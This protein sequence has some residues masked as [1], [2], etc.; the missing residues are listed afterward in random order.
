MAGSSLTPILSREEYRSIYLQELAHEARNQAFNLQA[1]LDWAMTGDSEQEAALASTL[2]AMPQVQVDAEVQQYLR[3]LVVPRDFQW[4]YSRLNLD[5]KK[6]IIL[7]YAKVAE[8]LTKQGQRPAS[9]AF[10]LS[11]IASMY[12]NNQ[13][14]NTNSASSV[15]N[16]NAAMLNSAQAN[17]ASNASTQT[18]LPAAPSNYLNREV[19]PPPPRQST[20]NATAA[21]SR[22]PAFSQNE[23]QQSSQQ[24]TPASQRS[25]ISDHVRNLTSNPSIEDT[26][27]PSSGNNNVSTAPVGFTGEADKPPPPPG[28][29]PPPPLQ[30]KRQTTRPAR[31]QQQPP[32]PPP[33]QQKPPPPPGRKKLSAPPVEAPSFAEQ[34][35]SRS[36]ELKPAPQ[37]PKRVKKSTPL[38]PNSSP[39][40]EAI[41]SVK[42]KTTQ[43]AS[44]EVK[45][46][47]LE[48]QIESRRQFI[49]Q[50]EVDSDE[51]D[52]EF[53]DREDVRDVI[54][55]FHKDVGNA[56]HTNSTAVNNLNARLAK[57]DYM[58]LNTKSFA[59]FNKVLKN[60]AQ[61]IL[62]RVGKVG[63]GR[64]SY[65]AGLTASGRGLTAS[66][67]G[68]KTK[69]K[70]RRYLQGAGA[71]KCGPKEANHGWQEFGKYMLARNDLENGNNLHIRYRNGQKIAAMPS[72]T[73]GGSMKAVLSAIAD[74]KKPAYD[75]LSQITDSEKTY[76]ESLLQ[77][78]S[79]DPSIFAKQT[80]TEKQREK[81]RFEL[82]KG[83][84]VAGNDNPSIIKEFKH[85]LIQLKKNG[86]LPTAQV[87]E[88]LLELNSLGH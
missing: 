74:G 40:T 1:N 38:D 10:F 42:L 84:I 9:G 35:K 45:K 32:P 31:K 19:P 51:S 41:R 43:P 60:N 28:A 8:L 23:A 16:H 48:K 86:T 64:F 5:M 55:K 68:R 53:D 39:F 87:Q 61:G 15:A 37:E 79:L 12:Q 11:Q 4:V 24:T 29:G 25:R 78:S 47:N 18:P 6:W 70:P 27:H 54:R 56:A 58:P 30:K 13:I 80:K 72:I 59:D 17:A 20:A 26:M 76:V 49:K 69:T 63:E 44:K 46:S 77:K 21:N 88:I 81:D 71:V 2:A 36:A 52:N 65:G 22:N 33:K 3:A 34:V 67:G 75:K 50:D 62:S 73:V 66:G 7:N 57:G 83:Q 85:M 14:Y 82:L